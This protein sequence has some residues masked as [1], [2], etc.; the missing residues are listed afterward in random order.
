MSQL[1]TIFATRLND[2]SATQQEVP[3]GCLRIEPDDKE[4]ITGDPQNIF[5]AIPGFLYRE[6]QFRYMKNGSGGTLSKDALVQFDFS[7]LADVTATTNTNPL[8]VLRASGSFITDGWKAGDMLMVID[9]AGAAGAA[10]EGEIATVSNVA[11]LTLTLAVALTAAVTLN[12]TVRCI[13]QGELRASTATLGNQRRYGV[14]IP[15]ADIPTLQYGWIQI[16]GIYPTA[17]CVAAGT[18]VLEGASL[19]AGTALLTTVGGVL[20]EG[21]PNVFT[22]GTTYEPVATALQSASSDTVRR[23]IAVLL[24]GE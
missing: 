13:R 1:K 7:T 17:N 24:K 20:T 15:M 8:L 4:P 16:A 14:G 3:L 12:D 22:A 21:T 18:A 19:Y 11:A 5:A 2:V 9:D 10:P 6:R 23:K